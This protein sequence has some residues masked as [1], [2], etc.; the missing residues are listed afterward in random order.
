[1][2]PD[3]IRDW[4]ARLSITQREAAERLGLSLRGYQKYESGEAA[5]PRSI[6]LACAAIAQG[7]EPRSLE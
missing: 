2:T 7:I 6:E 3:Q 5:I 4:R 1:V